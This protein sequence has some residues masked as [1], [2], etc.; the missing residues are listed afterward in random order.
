MELTAWT[1]R[2]YSSQ[3]LLEQTDW[4][5]CVHQLWRV[6]VPE[7]TVIAFEHLSTITDFRSTYAILLRPLQAIFEIFNKILQIFL[8][9]FEP[10]ILSHEP[11]ETLFEQELLIDH[12]PGRNT[13]GM[14]VEAV[15]LILGAFSDLT[16]LASPS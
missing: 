14:F 9:L 1:P 15:G 3:L 5:V 6:C 10:I 11:A 2:V 7:V 8:F 12:R 13:V 4:H 16:P